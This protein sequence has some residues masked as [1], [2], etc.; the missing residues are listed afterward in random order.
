VTDLAVTERASLTDLLDKLGP[1]A[2]TL[3]DGWET[4]DLVSHLVLRERR[5]DAIA[6]I[7]IRPL[8]GWTRRVQNGLARRNFSRLVDRLR[9]GPPR[10]SPVR[11]RRIDEGTNN[12]EFFVHHEDIRRAQPDWQPRA[13]NAEANELLWRRT[14]A[15]ARHALH[16]NHGVE[17]VRSDTGERYVARSP[18]A[19]EGGLVVAGAPQELLLYVFGRYDHALVE[20]TGHAEAFATLENREPA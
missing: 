2:P 10:W 11:L 9:G 17:L 20:R 5:L 1:D 19:G 14:R 13:L 7:V 4:R 8:S 3:C 15:I 18:A 12:I 6:G 16:T